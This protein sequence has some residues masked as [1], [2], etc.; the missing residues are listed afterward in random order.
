MPLL[1][2]RS[3]FFLVVA[4]M[5]AITAITASNGL[6]TELIWAQSGTSV[7]LSPSTLTVRERETAALTVTVSPAPQ[8]DLNLAYVIEADGD[9]ATADADAEDY[10]ASGVVTIAAGA[11]SGVINVEITDDSDIYGGAREMM[12]VRLTPSSG[13]SPADSGGLSASAVVTIEEGVCDRTAAV[14]DAIVAK[15]SASDCWSVTDSDLDGIT[16]LSLA[17]NNSGQMKSRD[18]AGL[19]GLE[20]WDLSHRSKPIPRWDVHFGGLEDDR[21]DYTEPH[22]AFRSQ[23]GSHRQCGLAICTF[24]LGFSLG[25]AE[26]SHCW[27]VEDGDLADIRHLVIKGEEGNRMGELKARDLRG[28]TGLIT[29]CL[30]DNEL[31]DLPDHVFMDQSQMTLL[32]L[33][34]NRLSAVRSGMWQGLSNLWAVSLAYNELGTVTSLEDGFSGL[35]LLQT[36]WLTNNGITT[37]PSGLFSSVHLPSLTEVILEHNEMGILPDGVFAGATNLNNV[38]VRRNPGSKLKPR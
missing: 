34:G 27:E 23:M 35:S 13:A 2:R 24:H 19:F 17:G 15:L 7:S 21:K 38:M 16:D 26:L 10:T 8:A 29:L 9:D 36:L 3:R 12:V 33:E 30:N 6:W 4:A 14:R 22:I 18:L 5:L 37:L 25:K 20:T 11:S 1:S 31:T 32:D 28:L